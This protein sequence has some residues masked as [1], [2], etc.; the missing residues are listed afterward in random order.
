MKKLILVSAF[1]L[2]GLST[3]AMATV[4]PQ[5]ITEKEI[6]IGDDFKEI[7]TSELPAAVTDALK[8]DFAT[9]TL[10]NAYVNDKQEYKLKITVDGAESVVYADKD[11][12]WI[13]K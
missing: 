3:F 2:G 13:K 4:L 5:N 10:N 8:K 11:G 7:K 6:I 9:A 1:V 12:N